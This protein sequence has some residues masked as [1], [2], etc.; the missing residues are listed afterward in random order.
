MMAMLV[1]RFRLRLS[2]PDMLA[3]CTRVFPFMQ[4]V[5]GTDKVELLPREQP[6]PVPGIDL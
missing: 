1:R 4:P 3:R 5:P 2:A 6:L